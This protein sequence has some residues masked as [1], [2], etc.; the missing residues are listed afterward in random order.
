M[1]QDASTGTSNA[2]TYTMTGLPKTPTAP[3]SFMVV[4]DDN[5]VTLTAPGQATIASGS[6]TVT[7]AKVLGGS[8]GFTASGGKAVL[9]MTLIY[10]F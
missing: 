4:V 1:Y 2:T 8:G 9:G 10:S 5:G 7:F 3:Q 6:T